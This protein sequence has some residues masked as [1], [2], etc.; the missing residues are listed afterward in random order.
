MPMIGP[1]VAGGIIKGILI[2]CVTLG[3][4]TK[5]DGNYLTLYAAAD[6]LLYFMPI[7]VGFS[8]GKVFKCNP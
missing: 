2:I 7:I 4:M 5:T 6:A 3:W 1:M 8:A